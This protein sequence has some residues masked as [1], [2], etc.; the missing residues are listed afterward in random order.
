MAVSTAPGNLV[1]DQEK[2]DRCYMGIFPGLEELTK[3]NE[4]F[5]GASSSLGICV[6][7]YVD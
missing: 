1:C 5:T 3:G 7:A 2:I 6:E 4:S